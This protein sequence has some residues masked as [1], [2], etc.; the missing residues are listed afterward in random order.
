MQSA[1]DAARA[2]DLSRVTQASLACKRRLGTAP[3]TGGRSRIEEFEKQG[4]RGRLRG[5]VTY[6]NI[7]PHLRIKDLG[8]ERRLRVVGRRLVAHGDVHESRVDGGIGQ[9]TF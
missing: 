7:S 6:N 4:H 8:R 3:G 1:E 2:A 5:R 9:M